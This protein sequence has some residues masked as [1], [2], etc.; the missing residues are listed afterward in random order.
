MKV[1]DTITATADGTVT[2]YQWYRAKDA[3]AT[4]IAGATSKT[5]TVTSADAGCTLYC[6]VNGTVSSA[7][8]ERVATNNEKSDVTVTLSDRD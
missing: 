5:Y 3:S 4:A 7:E 1:G 2:S 6:I 8:T